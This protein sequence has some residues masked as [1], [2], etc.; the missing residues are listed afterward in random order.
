MLECMAEMVV[1]IDEVLL[2]EA[3]QV[4]GTTT[5]AATI[6]EALRRVV[7][8]AR[9]RHGALRRLADEGGFD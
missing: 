5:P 1:D 8:E 4:L 3:A 6:A 9:V 7:A 2:A